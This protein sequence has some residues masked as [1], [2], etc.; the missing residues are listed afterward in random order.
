MVT[1]VPQVV[2]PSEEGSDLTL[3]DQPEDQIPEE[4]EDEEEE[5]VVELPTLAPITP[6]TKKKRSSVN[7]KRNS[8]RRQSIAS[9]HGGKPS[10]KRR[11]TQKH[12]NK[13]DHIIDM[14]SSE[15]TLPNSERSV[16]SPVT[17]TSEDNQ[18]PSVT[19]ITHTTEVRTRK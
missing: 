12:K 18:Q 7:Q 13:D 16:N 10:K 1:P 11:G 4:V 15:E 19:V 2:S 5:A 3:M 8:V 14:K 17:V 9:H 6:K